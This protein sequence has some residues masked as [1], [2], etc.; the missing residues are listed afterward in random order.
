MYWSTVHVVHVSIG[1]NVADMMCD[2][3]DIMKHTQR[4]GDDT[5]ELEKALLVMC[6]VPKAAN[7]MM[8]VGRLQ[9]Y[10]VSGYHYQL[11]NIM[12]FSF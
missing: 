6:V 3:Q 4:M 11:T 7:D 2:V 9:G 5:K 10:A 12:V 8:S 1:D